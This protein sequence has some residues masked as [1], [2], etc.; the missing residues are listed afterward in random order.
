[1]SDD[2]LDGK[3]ALRPAEVAYALGLS[4]KTIYRLIE[5]GE[6]PTISVGRARLIRVADIREWLERGVWR[7]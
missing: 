5:S 1:M 3:L 7:Q 4:A 2:P 6:L